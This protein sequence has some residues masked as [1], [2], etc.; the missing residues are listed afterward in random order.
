M[1]YGFIRVC[2]ATPEIRVADVEFNTE[3]IIKAIKQSADRGSRVTVFPELCVCGYTC[4]DL[5]NQPQLIR[6]VE[7]AVIKICKATKGCE[8]LVFIGAPVAKFG[9]LYNCAVAVCDGK[10]LGVVPKRFL[11]NYGEFYEKRHF[12]PRP[13]A[14]RVYKVRTAR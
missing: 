2:A 1:Q 11:P 7:E 4:G 9:R 13:C 6:C 10:V 12:S 3:Q 8:T 14:C 5:F